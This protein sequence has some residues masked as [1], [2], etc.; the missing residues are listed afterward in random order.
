MARK[1]PK[2]FSYKHTECEQFMEIACNVLGGG[3]EK[4]PVSSNQIMRNVLKEVTW[5]RFS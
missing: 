5:I 1:E 4:K 2:P 3:N